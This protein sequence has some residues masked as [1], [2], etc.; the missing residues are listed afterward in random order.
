MKKTRFILINRDSLL[1]VIE[2][3]IGTAFP[4]KS[5]PQIQE[6]NCTII[7]SPSKCLGR[8][9]LINVFVN[10]FVNVMNQA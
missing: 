4:N 6:G 7:F 3:T 10:I 1:S 2:S 8:I 5:V 9:L